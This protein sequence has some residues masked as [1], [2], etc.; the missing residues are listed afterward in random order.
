MVAAAALLS[1]LAAADR[2][3]AW[4]VACADVLLWAQKGSRTAMPGRARV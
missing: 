4:G 2:G 1:G 3:V